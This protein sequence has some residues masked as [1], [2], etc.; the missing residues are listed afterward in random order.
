VFSVAT[1]LGME[2]YTISSTAPTLGTLPAG[3]ET[4]GSVW[5]LAGAD[6]DSLA[7][8]ASLPPDSVRRVVELARLATLRG[9]GS[10]HAHALTRAGLRGVCDLADADAHN[11]WAHL[12]ALTPE[13]GRRPTEAEVRV[14]IRAARRACYV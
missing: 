1:L 11:L 12:H 9:I 13:L 2:R 8:T 4:V 10:G 6:P 14:W 3:L 7:A 5:E